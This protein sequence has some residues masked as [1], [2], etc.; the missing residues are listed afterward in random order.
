MNLGPLEDALATLREKG[1]NESVIAALVAALDGGLRGEVWPDRYDLG[2]DKLY[3]EWQFRASPSGEIGHGPLTTHLLHVPIKHEVLQGI[4]IGD[5]DKRMAAID[6][7]RP[8]LTREAMTVMAELNKLSMSNDER[9]EEAADRLAVRHWSWAAPNEGNL[10]LEE[11]K[12][13]FLVSKTYHDLPR[14]SRAYRELTE[15]RTNQLNDHLN[16]KSMNLNNLEDLR[17]ELATLKF[18]P[19]LA[20]QLEAKMRPLPNYFVLKDQRPGDNGQVNFTLHFKKSN[21]SDF[22]NMGKVDVSYGKAPV[23]PPDQSYMVITQ[24]PEKEGKV[25]TKHFDNATD[26]IE[27]YKKQK[28][29]SELGVGTDADSKQLLASKEKGKDIYLNREFAPVF[30]TPPVNQTFYPEKGYGFTA[31][32]CANMVQG[33]T[34]FR[35]DMMTQ[36]GEPY[37]AWVKLDFDTPKDDYGNRKLNNYHVPAYGFDV[38]KTLDRYQIKE[39]ADPAQRAALITALEAGNRAAVTTLKEGKEVPMKIDLSARYSSVDFFN[40][41]GKREK[42]EQFEKPNH[43]EL[44]PKKGQ[45]QKQDQQHSKGVKR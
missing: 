5:L 12:Q 31:E 32:Q 4:S 18:S 27:F 21:Q 23:L 17:N 11:K 3:L 36:F 19:E 45:E 37:A 10:Y 35:G 42:R 30:T 28:G 41:D 25:L 39:L 6:W 13:E 1:Y 14:L 29:T 16:K 22:Y 24:D 34:V 44:G 2:P 43:L 40:Q 26:A 8:E 20:D 7:N 38:N 15:L 9:S 33:R